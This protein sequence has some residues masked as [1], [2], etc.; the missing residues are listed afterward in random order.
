[1]RNGPSGRH[2]LA[3]TVPSI[4][5]PES[6]RKKRIARV[7]VPHVARYLLHG[8]RPGMGKLAGR[9]VIAKEDVGDALTFGARQPGGDQGVAGVEYGAQ[10]HG[11]ARK[12]HR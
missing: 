9:L 1:M 2:T 10:D 4:S 5:Q 12:Q 3:T 7:A 8:S 6:I 11:P